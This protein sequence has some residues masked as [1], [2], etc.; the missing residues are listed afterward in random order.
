MRSHIT[1]S[2]SIWGLTSALYAMSFV[3]L[4]MVWTFLL[5]NPRVLFAFAEIPLMCWSQVN[6]ELIS[7][8]RYIEESGVS[9]R[10]YWCF[11]GSFFLDSLMRW[12]VSG[13]YL[14]PLL[15]PSKVI[16]TV[17]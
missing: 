1:G 10:V 9:N 6:L 14:I 4:D 5:T 16:E 12:Q 8:P 3:S 17:L 11:V 7:T 13:L 2:Y 15:P